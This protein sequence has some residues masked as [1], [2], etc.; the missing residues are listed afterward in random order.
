MADSNAPS[1]PEKQKVKMADSN[2][3]S[4]PEKQKV[5]MADS[6]LFSS[7]ENEKVIGTALSEMEYRVQLFNTLSHTC[8]SKCVD[9]RY[10]EGELNLGE[11]TCVNRC[12]AKYYQVN[13]MVGQLLAYGKH[14]R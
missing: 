14:R 9:R 4:T 1:T 12:V 11:T 3:P 2:S 8:F 10:K 6:N 7:L 13:N 5:E